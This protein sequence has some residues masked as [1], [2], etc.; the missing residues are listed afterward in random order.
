MPKVLLNIVTD[1][2]SQII[3]KGELIDRYYNPGEVFDQVHIL[4]TNDDSPD[5]KALQRTVGN[6]ELHLH[7]LPSSISLLAK[8]LWRP[9]LLKNWAQN[10]VQR[11]EKIKPDLIRCYGNFLNGVPAVEIK[12]KLG[13]P[14]FV[15]LHTQPDET[16]ANQYADFKTKVFYSLS[17]SL[18]R[19]TLR[20]ADMVGAV[21]GSIENYTT[22][23][24]IKNV[25]RTYNVINND[26][27]S[28]KQD[29]KS[30]GP[31]KILHVGRLV[32]GK[33]PES[34]IKALPEKD[35]I[36]TVIGDGSKR[37]DLINLSEKLGLKSKVTFK[38]SVSNDELCRTMKDYDL[39]AVHSQYGEI[40]KTV[41]ETSLNGLPILANYKKGNPVPEYKDGWLKMVEDNAQG[42]GE[43]IDFYLKEENRNR[44]GQAAAEYAQKHWNPAVTEKIFADIHKELAGIDL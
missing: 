23:L 43:G 32:P 13:T 35:A 16:R 18:E 24:G 38:K 34:I 7:N 6:A 12:K 21:Y 44:M 33:N 28:L 19:Y 14:L 39:F 29:Y 17:K 15:S 2:L 20:N 30:T 27:L 8:T 41:L 26:N 31:L 1:R 25:K 4:M 9:L 3:T 40:P 22:R 10:A 37:E 11:A 5:I 42:Y 36:L